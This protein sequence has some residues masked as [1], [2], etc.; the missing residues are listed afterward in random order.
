PAL[1]P[2]RAPAAAIFVHDLAFRIRLGGVAC[3]ERLYFPVVLRLARPQA[4]AVLVPSDSTRQYLLRLIP[5]PGLAQRLEVIPE[6]LTTAVAAGAL[7]NGV[8]PGFVLAVGTVEPRKNYP[9]L[10]AAYRQLRGRGAL[11]F[12]LNGRPGVPQLVIAGR[13]GWA[14]GDTLQR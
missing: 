2:P 7:P 3:Q 12:I 4:S 9:R 1:R 8:E 6:G 14:Y 11:P 13:P 10:L 5:I